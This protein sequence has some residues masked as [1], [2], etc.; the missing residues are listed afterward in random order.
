[1]FKNKSKSQIADIVAGIVV[2]FLMLLTL[3]PGYI[4]F[5]K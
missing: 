3:N 1:M 2:G 4:F 5:A